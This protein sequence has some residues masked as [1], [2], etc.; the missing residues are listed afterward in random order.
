MAVPAAAAAPRWCYRLGRSLYV[1][2]TSAANSVTLV[3]SRGPGFSAA[4]LPPGAR[5]GAD[6]QAAPDPGTEELAQEVQGQLA[7]EPADAVVFAGTGEPTLAL[8]QLLALGERLRGTAG[9]LRLNTNGLGSLQHGRDIVP[10]LRSAGIT[11]VSVA[12]NAPT[13]ARHRCTVRPR[14][15]GA[16]AEEAFSAACSFVSASAAAFPPAS[17]EVTCV[18]APGIDAA[19]VEAL[20]RDLTPATAQVAFR[21]RP[22]FPLVPA[23]A[24]PLH[25]AAY[26][27]DL[28]AL[29]AAEAAALAA[30]DDRGNPPIIWAAEAGCLEAVRALAGRGCSVD[31]PGLS[32][33]AALHRACNQGHAAVAEELL[34]LRADPDAYNAKGQTALHHAAFYQHADCV[35]ALLAG[36]ADPAKRDG[37]GRTPAED[38]ADEAVR[39]ILLAAAE[40]SGP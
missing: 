2:V 32:G 21:E 18:A 30:P 12:L 23:E 5:T 37:R 31:T 1:H 14:V 36:G 22:F 8:G 15:R 29:A 24:F 10:E 27:G 9:A 3:Q 16:S 39:T 6:G 26:A 40:P 11:G 13:S 35:R 28:S 7:A 20:V 19:A 4:F 25:C 33:N 34:R 17:V 38:T